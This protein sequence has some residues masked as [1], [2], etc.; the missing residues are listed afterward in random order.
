[1]PKVAART[2]PGGR[3]PG[4]IAENPMA[5]FQKLIAES[6]AEVLNGTPW[7]GHPSRFIKIVPHLHF[8]ISCERLER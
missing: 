3:S 8:I 5:S 1:M 2:A 6:P 7:R 4:V